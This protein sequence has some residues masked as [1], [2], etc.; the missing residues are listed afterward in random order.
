MVASLTMLTVS[1]AGAQSF[2]AASHYSTGTD[3]RPL[4]VA[5][6]DVTGDG[7]ADLLTANEGSNTLGVLPGRGDGTFGTAST[8]PAGLAPQAVQ[9]SDL[10]GDG[11]PDAVLAGV[12]GVAVLKGLP[13]GKFG[14]AT[15]YPAS[16]SDY[17]GSLT[18]GDVNHDGR[19]DVVTVCQSNSTAYV[20][21]NQP[22]GTLTIATYSLGYSQ[23]QGVVLGDVTGDGHP[24]LV[25]SDS[26]SILVAKGTGTGSFEPPQAYLASTAGISDTLIGLGL[27]DLDGDGLLDVA[28]VQ[29]VGATV[30]VLHNQGGGV[31]HL[32]GRYPTAGLRPLSLA[33]A[34]VTGDG[35]PDVVTT[36]F[37]SA[38]VSVLPGLGNGLL[39]SPVVYQ[40]SPNGSPIV[41][42]LGDLNANSLPDIIV[43]NFTDYSVEVLLNSLPALYL[44]SPHNGSAGSALTLR[45][46]KLTG[47]TAVVFSQG[48]RM[49]ASVPASSFTATNYSAAPQTI[50]LP[51]PTIL[52][53]GPYT[54]G[55]ITPAGT[56]S[57]L[58]FSV[59]TPLAQVSPA[60]TATVE[61]TP[62]PAHGLVNVV[63]PAIAGVKEV[64]VRLYD[65]LGRE[66]FARQLPLPLSGLCFPLNVEGL[67][68]GLYLLR[69]QAGEKQI[70]SRLLL[71]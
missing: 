51:I 15:T 2:D 42:A 14:P 54:V 53:P 28:A 31:F 61:I 69:T 18:V 10:D 30:N 63:A 7:V 17:P 22:D 38:S 9:L 4:S 68:A 45:G 25:I 26:E 20:L 58:P 5:V 56:T 52:A 50:T 66:V 36:N 23:P 29:T 21:L 8:Y 62:N 70:I 44:N 48:S 1:Q 32:V 55:V 3:S 47:A 41:L 60:P 57:T 13:N 34:D 27:S 64:E 19:P 67:P 35:L 65:A 24:D 49:S 33:L 12:A 71:N 39:G 11:W 46:N 37:A 6:G 16:M 40:T 43:A 59:S